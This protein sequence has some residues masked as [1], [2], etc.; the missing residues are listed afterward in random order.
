MEKEPQ[1]DVSRYSAFKQKREKVFY[2]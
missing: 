1:K 2:N